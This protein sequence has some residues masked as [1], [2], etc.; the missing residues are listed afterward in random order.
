MIGLKVTL[1]AD[2]SLLVQANNDTRADL[3][4]TLK[5]NPQAAESDCFEMIRG[6]YIRRSDSYGYNLEPL[7]P[8]DVFALTDMPMFAD[9]CRDDDD[10]VRVYGPIW[11]FPDYCIRDWVAELAHKGRVI[12]E[13]VDD[14]GDGT[15][16]PSRHQRETKDEA[17]RLAQRAYEN[18]NGGVRIT[19]QIPDLHGEPGA[20]IARVVDYAPAAG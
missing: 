20:T 14:C 1:R 6:Q 16:F 11:G 3:A 5:S 9:N 10:S 4:H 2:G 12:F 15:T 18:C 7:W 8:G 13:Q 19:Q 17:E